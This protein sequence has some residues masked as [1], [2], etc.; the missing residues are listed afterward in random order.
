[1][2]EAARQL[3]FRIASDDGLDSF[4][5]SGKMLGAMKVRDRD[6]IESFIYAFSGLAGGRALIDGFVP[7]VFDTTAVDID[8]GSAG[9]SQ[10]LQRRLFESFR[11]VNALGQERSIL[12]IFADDGLTPPSGTG[13]CAGPKLLDYALRHG[14][15]PLEMGEFWYGAPPRREVR[16]QGSFY[17]SCTGK[18]GPLLRWMMQG[19]EVDPN[20]L[21]S[22]ALWT[23]DDPVVLHED[24]QVVV[25]IKPS[26]MLSVPGRGSRVSLE[27]WLGE[28]LG[29]P[30]FA[31]H[32]LDMDTSGL[33]VYAKSPGAQVELRRQFE[34]REISKAYMAVLTPGAEIPD[35]GKISLPLAPDW[36]DRP[37][38]MVDTAAGKP[39]VT[40]F[41]V[42]RRYGDGRTLVKLIPYTGRT[43]QLRVHCAHAEGL[44][45]PI[46][47]D[48]LYGS[49]DGNRLML[50]ASFL[51]FRHPATRERMTFNSTL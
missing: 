50:H 27:K 24:S 3:I 4:F 33:M 34:M 11:V 28:H 38:Q 23:L 44:G 9:E 22:D 20:P 30:V 37:R 49:P 5:A 32:R 6:G 16:R 41:E 40:D 36:Y 8:S 10:M 43:H 19:L 45:R 7:P 12:E 42:M 2:V 48:R 14:L 51:S 13:E 25:V 47:G 17:P 39:A 31:C 46:C 18:C 15:E 26:G 35:R 1:M 21:E 29:C